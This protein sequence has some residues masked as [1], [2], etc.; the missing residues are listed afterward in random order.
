MSVKSILLCTVL[1]LT[2]LTVS[3]CSPSQSIQALDKMGQIMKN[4]NTPVGQQTE[5]KPSTAQVIIY[6]DSN[7]NTSEYGDAPVDVWL[8]QLKDSDELNNV[9][10]YSLSE[11]PKK[12]LPSSYIRHITKQVNPGESAVITPFKFTDDTNF[13]GVVVAYGNLEK[14]TW[15][16]TEKVNP[17]GEQYKILIPVTRKGV[18][19]QVHR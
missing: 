12:A 4:P 19:I 9:D 6:A 10:Y 3:G 8:F 5:V 14:V 18:S 16:A 1:G 15:K 13:I 11:D 7:A 17:S 2:S